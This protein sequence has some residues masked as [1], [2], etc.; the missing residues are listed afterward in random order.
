[1]RLVLWAVKNEHYSPPRTLLWK[2][3]RPN[4]TPHY[5]PCSGDVTQHDLIYLLTAVGLSAG[6]STHLHTNNTY[7]NTNNNRK[8][9]I[10]TNVEEC[11]PWPVFASFTLAFGLQ[12]RIKHGKTSVRVRKPSVRLQYT[13]YQNTHTNTHI[14]DLLC[15]ISYPSAYTGESVW[16][17]FSTSLPLDKKPIA[18]ECEAGWSS[19]RERL[20]K[21]KKSSLPRMSNSDS[22]FLDLEAH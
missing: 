8:T 20:W 22:S 15:T 4:I 10:T 1:M 14:W 13:Y 3:K 5:E 16:L 7:N 11:G 21:K 12:L 2:K 17:N 6:G 9:Q 19:E 18:T